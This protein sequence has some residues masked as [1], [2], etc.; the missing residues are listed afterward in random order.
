MSDLRSSDSALRLL[1]RLLI[2]SR[3]YRKVLGRGRD[4]LHPCLCE[5]SSIAIPMLPPWIRIG[6]NYRRVNSDFVRPSLY[7]D[8]RYWPLGVASPCC[9][10]HGPKRNLAAILFRLAR[11]RL[12]FDFW[13]RF[14]FLWHGPVMAGS[15]AQSR[16]REFKL[17][18]YPTRPFLDTPE[19]GMLH[20]LVFDGNR[21]CSL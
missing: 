12:C 20:F 7:N 16:A 14:C 10:L 18:H 13:L 19:K 15:Q 5:K 11:L 8:L 1:N 21:Y 17:Y 4:H 6:F 3:I 9:L 2:L